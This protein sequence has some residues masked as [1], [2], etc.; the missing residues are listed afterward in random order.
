LPIGKGRIVREGSSVAILSFGTR[1]QEAEKAAT[2]LERYGLSTTVADARF[3]KPLDRDLVFRLARNHEVLITVEEGSVGGF[4]SHVL[5]EL[6]LAGLLDAGLKIR[7]MTLPDVFIDHHSPQVQ[8]DQAG[9]NAR[10]IA[11]TALAAL[12]RATQS[13]PARA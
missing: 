1:L 8:Y 13:L 5:H 2:E 12:G 9:L 10:H 6:A 3:M 11:A 7:P 4:G